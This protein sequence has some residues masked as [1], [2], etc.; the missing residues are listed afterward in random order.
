MLYKRKEVNALLFS[1]FENFQGLIDV[2]SNKVDTTIKAK[3]AKVIIYDPKLENGSTSFGSEV[4]ND[5]DKFKTMSHSIIANRYDKVL[6][7]VRYKVYTRDI[8]ER[9]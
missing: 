9:D 5:L 2:I 3:G 4:V 8:F 1:P 6:D 7:D